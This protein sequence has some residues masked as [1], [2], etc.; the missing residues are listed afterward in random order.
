MVKAK[1]LLNVVQIGPLGLGLLVEN[2]DHLVDGDNVQQAFVRV[3]VYFE[4]AVRCQEAPLG[5]VE[6]RSAI[7]ND[8]NALVTLDTTKMTTT[9]DH[10]PSATS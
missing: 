6:A 1:D 2:V 10:S 4:K 5:R 8:Q 3:V 9:F 7:L